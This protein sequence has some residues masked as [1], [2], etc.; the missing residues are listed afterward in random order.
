[1]SLNPQASKQTNGM[2]RLTWTP[3][4]TVFGYRFY[5]DGVAVA[6]G[7]R[8]EQASTTF[9]AETDGKSHWYGVAR[10]LAQVSE[11]VGFPASEAF[12]SSLAQPFPEIAGIPK[13]CSTWPQL[14]SALAA[15]GV[16]E[17]VAKIG[18]PNGVHNAIVSKPGTYVFGK[19]GTGIT[20]GRFLIQAS[21]CRLRGMEISGSLYDGVKIADGVNVIVKNV[22]LDGLWI[23]D[24]GD[25]GV[26]GG[27]G[28]SSDVW[29]RNCLIE[30][31]G[32]TLYPG[33]ADGHCV[34]TGGA[35]RW[36][37][38][39]N[40]FRP[41]AFAVQLYDSNRSPVDCVVAGNTCESSELRGLG[42][43]K[44]SGHRWVGNV[45]ANGPGGMFE[46]S[47]YQ[48]WGNVWWRMG[49]GYTNGYPAPPGDGGVHADPATGAKG[50][51]PAS[52]YAWLPPTFR[53]GT[54]RVTADAGARAL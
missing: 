10:A 31:V 22:D 49:G 38:I 46:G 39:L 53:D 7:T 1:M 19:P 20:N 11:S 32:L 30:R 18:I 16:I 34:Y 27:N 13:V 26:L 33:V 2:I 48:A 12:G 36:T 43:T 37:I 15:G 6:K 51:V 17:T 28:Q 45:S 44:G 5:R 24:V 35:T 8:P 3:D 9:K 4:L 42:Y 40:V 29:V 14:A 21:D 50:S 23:H 47:G 25:Q 52:Q 41:K 54:A